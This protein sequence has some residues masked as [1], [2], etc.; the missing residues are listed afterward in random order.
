MLL[1]PADIEEI[2]G[3]L[4]RPAAQARELEHLGI[5]FARRRDGSLVV[6]RAAVDRVLCPDDGD[7]MAAA[8]E[9][10]LRLL[11]ASAT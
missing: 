8:H 4:V 6:H 11:N 2:T 3:G 9:P 5:P 1:S 7:T 10:Q